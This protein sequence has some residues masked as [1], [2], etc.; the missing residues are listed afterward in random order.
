MK[1]TLEAEHLTN[2]MK[3]SRVRMTVLRTVKGPTAASGWL[4]KALTIV[5]AYA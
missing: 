5:A 1:G 2:Q 3:R 4:W